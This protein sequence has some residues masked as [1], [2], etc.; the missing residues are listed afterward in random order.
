[1]APRRRLLNGLSSGRPTAILLCL[2]V[3]RVAPFE[4]GPFKRLNCNRSG[5]RLKSPRLQA[6]AH[7]G[8]DDAVQFTSLG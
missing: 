7:R 5:L 2:L 8:A 1:M 3:A 4:L 6:L